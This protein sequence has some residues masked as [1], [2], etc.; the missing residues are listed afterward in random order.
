M[1]LRSIRY[2]GQGARVEPGGAAV[3][4]VAGIHAGQGHQQ[5]PDPEGHGSGRDG[6]P[7]RC[8][9]PSVERQAQTETDHD[10]TGS[11]D[12]DVTLPSRT[13]TSRSAYAAT[14]GSW[15]TR[16]TVVPCR[17]ARATNRF[18]TCSPLSESSEPVGSSA[19]RTSG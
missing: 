9:P 16:T 14:L 6:E 1:T 19:N 15:V 11:A 2:P 4:G 3:L 13:M 10:S 17:R 7:D 8:L 5:Q 12:I 18:M